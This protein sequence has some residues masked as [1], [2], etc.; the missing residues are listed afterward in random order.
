MNSSLFS[1]GHGNKK[2]EDFINEIKSLNINILI[3]IRS[4]PYS[5]WSPQFNKEQ[6]EKSLINSGIKYFY[7]GD[8]LGGLPSDVSCYDYKGKVIYDIIKDKNFFK[9]G[10]EKLI[11]ANDKKLRTVIMCSE[12]NPEECH[13]TK[14]IGQE[15]LKRKISL[16]HIISLNKTKSQET[17]MNELNK[18]LNTTDLW[19]NQTEFTSRKSY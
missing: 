13:R 16:N 5:K 2:I 7:M 14:L 9:E 18:G 3:D 8:T 17:V 1:I 15:L 4:K 10:L 12:A 19:G 6:L 11:I